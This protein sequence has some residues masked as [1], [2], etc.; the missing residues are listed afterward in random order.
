MNL[1]LKARSTGIPDSADWAKEM[2]AYKLILERE[3]RHPL[4]LEPLLAYVKEMTDREKQAM[5]QGLDFPF[6]KRASKKWPELLFM[7]L[8]RTSIMQSHKDMALKRRMLLCIL[9]HADI[10]EDDLNHLI[11]NQEELI[12]ERGYWS[13]Y[14]TLYFHSGKESQPELWDEAVQRIQSMRTSLPPPEQ[15]APDADDMSGKDADTGKQARKIQLLES[16]S[17]KEV[18]LRQKLEQDNA[19]KDKQLRLKGQELERI[20]QEL[21]REKEKTERA[22]AK[23]EQL[24]QWMQER[25]QQWKKEQERWLAER[26]NLLTNLQAA[27]ARHK[28]LEQTIDAQLKQHAMLAK[29][30]EQ[31]QQ[32]LTQLK[33]RQHEPKALAGKLIKALYNEMNALNLTL[34][35][36]APPQAASARNG[37]ASRDRMRKALDLVD[38]LD[39]FLLS[40]PLSESGQEQ[41]GAIGT[42]AG[43][44]NTDFPLKHHARQEETEPP[45]SA[46]TTAAIYGTF[47]RRD[48]GGYVK[49]E[50]GESFNITESLVYQHQ[51]QHEAE[52]LCTPNKQ[53]GK[54]HLYDIQLLF[55]GDDT[56]C[57]I[58]QYDGYVE[59]GEHHTWYCVDMNDAGNR[60][61]VH[62]KDIEIQKPVHGAP[63]TFNVAEDGHIARLTRIYHLPGFATGQEKTSEPGN[64]PEHARKRPV[65]EKGR[66]VQSRQK[67]EPFLPGCTITIIG[68][69]RKW[70]E[71]VVTESGAE[72]VH[73][74][75]EHPE[76]MAAE[77][78]RSQALFMLITS[79]S[80]RATWDGVDLA[81]AYGI[82]HFIIQGSKSN[83]RTLLWD[84][85]EIIRSSNRLPQP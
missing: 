46:P 38:A 61:P 76:R 28:Q 19:R 24:L 57:P 43:P 16:K 71:D 74:P 6:A 65:K 20:G 69:L 31:L 14:W 72:L 34:L 11:H 75:G 60:F 80:H 10:A 53:G 35:K 40:E 18:A 68:G 77:L 23:S 55:Q 50:N 58:Q 41:Q 67:P 17:A 49:L 22:A 85:R 78:K 48:H 5:A 73:E 82:P 8:L 45:V 66:S 70:F 3:E 47:Y 1:K 44:Q 37:K 27:N 54:P 2:E 33:N 84:N 79:T 25:E 81:K 62:Y 29:E 9:Q 4:P 83:L 15:Q 51:L 12:V 42:D 21:D 32:A 63:C 64:E 56:Y 36:H 26:Q 59:L 13:F 30:K 52:V 39:D 7:K